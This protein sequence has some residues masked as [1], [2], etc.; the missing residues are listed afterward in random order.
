MKYKK[1]WFT[2]IELTISILIISILILWI[3]FSIVKVSKNLSYT[4]QEVNIFSQIKDFYIDSN[5]F[6]YNQGEI[7]TGWILLHNNKYGILIGSFVDNFWWYNYSFRYNSQQYDKNLFWYFFIPPEMFSQYVWNPN[8]FYEVSFNDGKIFDNLFIQ[9]MDLY[10][11]NTGAI[12]RLELNIFRNYS[13]YFQWKSRNEILV[14][15]ED[16]LKFN[17]IF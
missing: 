9:Q 6:L 8:Y 2:L 7:L 16:I 14:P 13:D 4:M 12:I 15:K 10:S 11:Y 3:S 17:L 1:W 5:F